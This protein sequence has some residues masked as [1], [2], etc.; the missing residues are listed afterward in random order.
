MGSKSMEPETSSNIMV[1]SEG[2][3]TPS[4]GL[5]GGGITWFE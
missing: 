2:V 4:T 3:S 5:K 1:S